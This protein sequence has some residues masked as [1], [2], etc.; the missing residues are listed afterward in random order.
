MKIALFALL[1]CV[2]L[3]GHSF[4]AV[5]EQVVEYNHGDVVLEGFL[6]FDDSLEGP[7]PAVM[8]VHQWKGLG[9]YE[10]RRARQL[11]EL[12]Y[13]AFCAD[14]YG[15]GI[16][17][18]TFEEAGAEATKYRKDRPLQR[19][20]TAAGLDH[21]KTLPGVDPE[22]IT[23]IG[24]CFG[25]G[26]VL[27]LA[28]GG[29]DLAAVVSFHGNLDT[30][31]PADAKNIT[32]KVLVCHGANDKAVPAED[33]LAFQNEMRDAGVDWEMIFF[34]NAVHSFTDFDKV[35]DNASANSAYNEKADAR[36]WAAFLQ[37]LEEV[38]AG[39]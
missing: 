6:V 24:Y 39:K 38:E 2:A 5:Q 11:A 20:R 30:P 21:L 28:R 35:G 36:S 17:P 15:K 16:R 34:G 3:C 7:R 37:I 32:C 14:I 19:A 8:I 31:E 25:G 13:I 10:K 33:V 9:D 23:A 4:A 1:F 26:C 27:E 12:G 22:K 18:Q 29:A